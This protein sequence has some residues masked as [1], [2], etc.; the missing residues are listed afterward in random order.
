M[1]QQTYQFNIGVDV[2]KQKLDVSFSDNEIGQ[3]DNNAKGFGPFLKRIQ[4]PEDTRVILE[5]TGGYERPLVTFLQEQGIAVSVVNAKRVRDFAKAM[6]HLA[7]TDV[8]DAH[9]IR[10]FAGAINPQVTEIK[11]PMQQSLDALIHR[12]EQLVRQRS[13]EKQHLDTVI[14][15]EV[16]QSIERIIDL[17][18][19]EISLIE[20]RLKELASSNP[21][22]SEKLSRLQGIKG[23]GLI[24][25][26]IFLACLP[27]LGTLS[28]KEIS[29]LVG[30]APFCRDS[31]KMK[32]RR[33]IWGGRAQVRS[34]L[35]MAALS[36]IKYNEAIRQFY[37]RLLSKGKAKKVAIVACMRKLL[38]VA[39]SMI[40]HNTD[41]DADDGKLA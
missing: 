12:R 39:N 32:G 29:A 20:T 18:D 41:W 36:A 38:T 16:R 27:E 9:V 21:N 28:N 35:Y 22:S 5:A 15:E 13:V 26:M 40:K 11:S 19:K 14:D 1:M 3:F 2:S 30:V 17:L 25:A 37:E 23:I 7:K 8:I 24:T 6:G 33:G 34:T 31:G 4:S 10:Q